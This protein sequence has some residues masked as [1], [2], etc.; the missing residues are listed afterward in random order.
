VRNPH[1]TFRQEV[2]IQTTQ[3]NTLLSLRNVKAFL[4][5]NSAKFDGM[6]KTGV[7]RH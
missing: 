5:D 1:P 7:L 6:L 2:P 3:G 4:D